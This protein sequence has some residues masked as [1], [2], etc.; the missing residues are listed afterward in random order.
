[1]KQ[2]KKQTKVII[3]TRSPLLRDSVP[4]Q[5]ETL[6]QINEELPPTGQWTKTN[7]LLEVHTSEPVT[8]EIGIGRWPKWP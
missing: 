1:M 4:E 6:R 8:R 5:L 2:E 7:P 3:T